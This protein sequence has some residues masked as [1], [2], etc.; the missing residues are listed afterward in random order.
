MRFSVPRAALAFVFLTAATLSAQSQTP[1]AHR[2]APKAAPPQV[3]ATPPMGWN[4]W[5]Y[6]AEKVTDKD[7]RDSA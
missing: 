1:A 7:I 2:M 5:N 3:A 4:S 6:F